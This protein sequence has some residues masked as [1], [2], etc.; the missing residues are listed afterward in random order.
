ME[1][2]E[3]YLLFSLSLFLSL[4]LS[5]SRTETR[6]RERKSLKF[7]LPLSLLSSLAHIHIA[8]AVA[9]LPI[10]LLST[11]HRPMKFQNRRVKRAEKTTTATTIE[12]ERKR[13]GEKNEEG[14][15]EEEMEKGRDRPLRWTMM[16]LA[17]EK[18]D[19]LWCSCLAALNKRMMDGWTPLQ[20]QGNKRTPT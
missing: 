3:I 6:E 12:R 11:V 16:M 18:N 5:L 19:E 14:E 2:N 15:E 1:K 9:L 7:S 20:G 10:Y 8:R 4:S 17:T 13:D